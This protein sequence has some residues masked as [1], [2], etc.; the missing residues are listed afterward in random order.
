MKEALIDMG[1]AI[2]GGLLGALIVNG[3]YYLIYN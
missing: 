1:I 2:F 3:I